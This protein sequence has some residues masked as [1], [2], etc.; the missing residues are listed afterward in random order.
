[1]A[2]ITEKSNSEINYSYLRSAEASCARRANQEAKKKDRNKLLGSAAVLL[3]TG[4]L[5]VGVA[6][7]SLA[8]GGSTNKNPEKIVHVHKSKQEKQKK[9]EIPYASYELSKSAEKQLKAQLPKIEELRP[10]YEQAAEKT[11]MPWYLLA[12]IHYEE[13]NSSSKL[14]V[15][16][17]E[18]L[19]SANPD[20]QG[21][22]GYAPADQLQNYIAALK[23]ARAMGE[24]VYGTKINKDTK[25]LSKIGECLLAYNRGTIYKSAGLSPEDS[26]YVYS[27]LSKDGK[28]YSCIFPDADPL[29]GRVD[30]RP[31]GLAMVIYLAREESK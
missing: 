6:S 24:W 18:T 15:F 30:N 22:D 21:V 17:G 1:M 31:G 8:E 25:D 7:K 20:G 4:A 13:A 2:S 12:A 10:L 16:A 23:H 9:I 14:S 11:N 26:P 19:G 29:A 28:D 27:G 5:L 3:A